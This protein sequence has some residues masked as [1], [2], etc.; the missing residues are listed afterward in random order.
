MLDVIENCAIATFVRESP[1]SFGYTAV[2]ALHA[3]GLAVVVGTSSVVALRMLGATPTIPLRPLLQFFPL[4]YIG[5][6]VNAASGLALLAA[7]ASEM[8]SNVMF[9]VKMVFIIAAVFSLRLMKRQLSAQE[10]TADALVL[11]GS[12]RAL[13]AVSVC[14]WLAAIIAGRLTAYP[15]FVSAWF[16][17]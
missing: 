13:S 3:I 12:A 8:L 11:P 1:S 9:Y 16:G 15:Y 2:V 10:S 17:I 4:M 5:F 6:W 14:V 7:N